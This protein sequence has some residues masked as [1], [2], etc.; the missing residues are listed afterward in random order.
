MAG[1]TQ[2]DDRRRAVLADERRLLADLR[3]ALARAGLPP[4]DERTLASSVAQL[5]ELFLL[6]VVGEFNAGKSALLNALLGAPVLEEGVTPTTT[7]ITLV[8]HEASR[9]PPHDGRFAEV[10]AALDMLHETTLVDTP[11]TNAVLREHEALT[12]EFLP[13]ADLVLFVTS[14]DRPFSESERA[15]LETIR[16]WGKKVVLVLNKADLLDPSELARVV[17]YVADNARALLGTAAPVF[18]VRS[19]EARAAKERGDASMLARSGLADL[20]AH[21]ATT[22]SAAERFRLKLQSPLGVAT[23][24]VTAPL[25]RLEAGLAALKE[26]DLAI[27]QIEGQLQAQGE[28]M[29]RDFRYRLAD[30][31]N[32]LLDLEHRGQ[33]FFDEVLRL[34]RLRDLLSHDRLKVGFERTVVADLPQVVERRVDAIVEWMIVGGQRQWRAVAERL[35]RR[36]AI[37]A[38]RMV[39]RLDSLEPERQRH[40]E[41]VKH[42]AQRALAHYDR[43][44]EAAK[45]ARSVREAVAALAVLQAGALGLG[46][47]VT[48]LATTTLADV[49][50]ILAAGALSLLGLLLIPARRTRARAD[51]HEKV[52]RLRK[53]L[54]EALTTQ[55]DRE[56]ERNAGRIREAISPYTAYVRSERH[57]IEELHTEVSSLRDAVGGLRARLEDL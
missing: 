33:A 4:E 11:G 2:L 7:R 13:R 10:R 26:D 44:T 51:L 30:V 43:E 49:T 29:R 19:R 3:A 52:S 14:A 28:E 12:R 55:F 39:G 53:S 57:R 48:V 15:F 20:E 50:G 34:R 21:L 9:V 54:M 18:P 23:R 37:H 40:L 27:E 5:D 45:L 56:V 32:A 35:G 22:L 46:T 1:V 41:T 8:R 17:G 38:E 42:E 24:L 25:A 6:V 47:A 31:D 16:D 36:E